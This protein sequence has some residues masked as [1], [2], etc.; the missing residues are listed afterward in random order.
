MTPEELA[1]DLER[2]TLSIQTR[3]E[4]KALEPYQT[5]VRRDGPI[6]PL[7][8]IRLGAPIAL[9]AAKR[10]A[11]RAPKATPVTGAL[12]TAQRATRAGNFQGALFALA[13]ASVHAGDNQ[14]AIRALQAALAA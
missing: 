2:R 10:P 11:K 12:A 1:A 5:I 7:G 14:S 6:N 9:R 4:R 8:M 3:L 13:A